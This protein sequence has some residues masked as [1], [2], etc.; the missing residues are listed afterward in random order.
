[1]DSDSFGSSSDDNERNKPSIPISL[2]II[3]EDDDEVF[4]RKQTADFKLS[5]TKSAFYDKEETKAGT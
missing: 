5:K 3:E 1:M 2:A 4:L